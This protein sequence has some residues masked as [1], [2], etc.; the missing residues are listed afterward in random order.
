MSRNLK[1]A[2]VDMPS[3]DVSTS[4]KRLVTELRQMIMDGTLEPESKISEVRVSKMFSVSRTP[5]RLA[6]RALEVEGLLKK[7]EGR[8]YTVLSFNFDDLSKAY[9]VRGVLEGLAAGTLA[10]DGMQPATMS[11]LTDTLDE[12]DA[13]LNSGL[14]IEEC[15]ITYQEA[16]V[17]FHQT[18]MNQSSNE[19]IE[20]AFEKLERFPLLGLGTVIFNKDHAEGELMRLRFGN[21]QHRVILDAIDRRDAFRAET[22]MREHANQV[23]LYSSLIVKAFPKRS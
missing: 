1:I 6:L 13:L 3:D 23:P 20:F 4:D 17:H 19:F 21:M 18:I 22:L 15:V 12:V 11:D 5:A 16:N 10:R 2:Q 14:P 8:G 7:R 9:E